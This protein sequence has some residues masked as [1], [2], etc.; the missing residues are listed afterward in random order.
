[1]FIAPS[2]TLSFPFEWLVGGGTARS[3]PSPSS[4]ANRAGRKIRRIDMGKR[5]IGR[6]RQAAAR[7]PASPRRARSGCRTR[8]APRTRRSRASRTRSRRPGSRS[9]AK[10]LRPAQLRSTRSTGQSTTPSNRSIAVAMSISSGAASHGSVGDFVVRAQPDRP[11]ALAFEIESPG[12]SHRSAANPSAPSGRRG[13]E[14]WFGA[15]PRSRAVE[16]SPRAA[17]RS[18]QAP[19]ASTRIAQARRPPP[20]S[21]TDQR[22]PLKDASTSAD[23]QRT[24]PPARL[25]M[26]R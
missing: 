23:S 25:N 2:P 16:C 4:Q 20:A 3:P 6:P 24:W 11:V 26:R 12:R 14:P 18:A 1:M 7:P 8:P 21:C 22:L 19:A 15:W 17:T 5:R 13:A 9:G 10:L